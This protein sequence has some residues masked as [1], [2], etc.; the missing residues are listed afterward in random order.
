MS[1]AA[2]VSPAPNAAIANIGGYLT[3]C[4]ND[5][6]LLG[7]TFGVNANCTYQ[8]MQNGANIY[9]A[10]NAYYAAYRPGSYSVVVSNN[11]CVR[12]SNILNT[13]TVA[14]PTD[15][16]LRYDHTVLCPGVQGVILWADT[17]AGLPQ[18][19][20]WLMNNTPVAGATTA[21][22]AATIPT[23]YSLKIT[24]A[25]TGCSIVTRP[26]D[27]VQATGPLPVVN[28]M[29]PKFTT[30]TFNNYQWYMN[31]TAIAGATRATLQPTQ[32][33]AYTVGVTDNN[34]CTGM[35]ANFYFT[36]SGVQ[37]IAKEDVNIYPNPA[38][39]MVYINVPVAV[40]AMV[41]SMDGRTIFNGKE[42]KMID[43]STWA[44]GVYLI[45]ILDG[46]SVVR[47]DKLIK[48]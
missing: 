48:K 8:W 17:S 6:V 7:P 45:K 21:T 43:I 13:T 4:S 32:S 15:S 24:D 1:I 38:N 36:Y 9:G 14:A 22:Y 31:G 30:G 11:G 3:I 29:Y 33:G 12:T 18:S 46:S 47:I 25:T 16:V 34:G 28:Y 41:Y 19:Y 20:Q 39:D 44:S 2:T 40:N 5:S 42:V 35:S 26:V 27:I 23:V 10:T 37:S